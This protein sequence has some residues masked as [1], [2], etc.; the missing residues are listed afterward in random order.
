M[1]NKI[2]T[3]F[4]SILTSLLHRYRNATAPRWIVLLVDL[5]TLTFAFA[6]SY[7]FRLWSAKHIDWPSILV[8]WGT[9]CVVAS[10]CYVFI[11]THRSIIR[12]SG[13]YDIYKILVSNIL[14]VLV[15]SIVNVVNNSYP[16]INNRFTAPYSVIVLTFALQIV[17]MMLVRLLLQRIY[18]DY[19]R[20]ERR[21][22]NIIIFGAGAAGTLAYTALAQDMTTDY[23]VVAY[24][25]DNRSKVNTALN[26]VRVMQRRE[27]LNEKFI[28]QKKVSILLIA[29]PSLARRHKQALTN[30]GLELGLTVKSVPHINSWINGTF[31]ANQIKDIQIEDL[32]G[33]DSIQIDN[34]N[35]TREVVEKTVLVTGA[36]GSIG[37]EI[38]RQLMQY[39]PARIIML[40]Q[41]ESPMYDLQYELRNDSK[42][43]HMVSRMV[44]VIANVKDPLRM[45]EVFSTYKPQ[46]IYHAAAYKHVPFMEEN[47]YEAILVNVF[48][49][50]NIADL[51]IKYG[52][53]KFV[54]ISTDKAV[55][56]T[57]V[58][59]CSKR[60]CE[61]YCQSLNRA[62]EKT[63][64][65]GQT[66]GVSPN[67][68]QA[69]G[70]LPCTQFVTTRF[71][72]VLGSNGSV[73]P[74]FKDQI[75]KGGPVTVTHPDI[76]RY[77]M[78]IPEACKLVLEAGTMGKG[79][80]IFVFDMGKPVRIADLARRMITLSGAQDV[81][82]EF[83]GLRD[84]EKLYEEVLTDTEHTL[85]T[86]HPKIMVA[87]VREYDYEQARLNEERLL[88][89]S[90]TYDDMAIV[91]IM[92]EIVPE[93]K[94]HQSKYEALD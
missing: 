15:L 33:R 25:D 19:V 26:G 2:S 48:G 88:E 46:I 16:I 36:A 76:I 3:F 70:E 72:N 21:E 84:G 6:I 22:C 47:P 58:M 64:E 59:G 63:R 71:G 52:A 77:F 87:K 29:V 17:F 90:Y 85:P 62:I 42:Y 23:K 79:G 41:A 66:E 86:V 39:M 78:L 54:M 73:I 5:I 8:E 1:I 32:L 31:S 65:T 89:A 24:I 69:N 4:R 44:F 9:F 30:K 60:I 67:L 38:C 27:A 92:K 53:D 49:T 14:A 28:K 40:D 93:F 37:S 80:E 13:M 56:P 75:A 34:A 43:S 12:H 94:S 20:E 74:I 50:K 7:T 55:N 57:N 45:E 81:K 35:I 61:I 51:A 10:V 82:V 68:L 18:N 83:T 91:K 11:G